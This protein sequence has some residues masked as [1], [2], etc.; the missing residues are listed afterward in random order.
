MWQENEVKYLDVLTPFK[1]EN[2]N[3][4]CIF[5]IVQLIIAYLNF[6]YSVFLYMSKPSKKN[7]RNINKKCNCN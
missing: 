7:F 4:L 6:K 1:C 5:D 2:N 3:K